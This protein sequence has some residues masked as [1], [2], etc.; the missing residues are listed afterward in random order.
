MIWG[1]ADAALGKE[2]TYG[3]GEYVS[4]LTLRYL[5]NVSHWVQQE[6]PETVNA[7]MEA[8]LLDREVP[9]APGAA[10]SPQDLGRDA[11][12][13]PSIVNGGS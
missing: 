10:P 13:K 11:G 5:P 9:L 1:E 12:T 6:A 8:W 3:T 2:L 4:H 7:M